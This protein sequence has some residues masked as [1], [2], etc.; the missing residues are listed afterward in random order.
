MVTKPETWTLEASNEFLDK[1]LKYVKETDDCFTL[2]E[3]A[4]ECGEYEEVI[5]YI[6]N[7]FG[8]NFKSVK[9]AKEI[10]KSRC[11]KQGM[12][13]KTQPTMTI[14]NLVNNFGMVN[15][16]QKNNNTNENKTTLD[17]NL[18]GLTNKELDDAANKIA[19]AIGNSESENSTEGDT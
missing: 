11:I 14:F 19:K 9:R 5:N 3:A 12:Q 13:F 6:E 8:Q 18:N 17:V 4:V 15:T 16:N 1:V 7:K 2:G 10:I